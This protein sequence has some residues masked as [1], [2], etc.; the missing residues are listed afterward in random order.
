M[1]ELKIECECPTLARDPRFSDHL[2]KCVVMSVVK[3]LS[4]ERRTI[5]MMTGTRLTEHDGTDTGKKRDA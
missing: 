4:M 3:N 1:D 5:F 2:L